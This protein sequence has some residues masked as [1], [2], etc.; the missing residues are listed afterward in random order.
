MKASEV[1]NK[2]AATPFVAF[3]LVT[4]ASD[5]VRVTDA[6]QIVLVADAGVFYIAAGMTQPAWLPLTL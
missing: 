6:R 2:L 4:A 3:D 1:R 5:K